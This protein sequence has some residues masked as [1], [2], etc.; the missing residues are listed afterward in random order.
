ME[1]TLTQPRRVPE[2]GPMGCK[3]LLGGKNPGI[4]I[5]A[6]GTARISTG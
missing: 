6:D 4:L 3:R 1:A 2:D 5:P